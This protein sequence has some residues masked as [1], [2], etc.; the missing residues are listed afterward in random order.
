[1]LYSS[2][3]HNTVNQLY[4]NK[5]FFKIEKTADLHDDNPEASRKG[6]IMPVCSVEEGREMELVREGSVEYVLLDSKQ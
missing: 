6:S 5:K 2:N 3:E 4:V 1:M